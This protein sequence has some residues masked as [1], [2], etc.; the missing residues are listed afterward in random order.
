MA[1]DRSARGN[2]PALPR[3]LKKNSAL[4]GDDGT[5]L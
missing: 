5:Y 2:V 1:C 3:G 4:E